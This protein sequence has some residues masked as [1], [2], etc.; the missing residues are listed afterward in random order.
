M[1]DH[2]RDRGDIEAICARLRALLQETRDL[3]RR[4]FLRALGRAGLAGVLTPGVAG[5]GSRARAAERPVT[6]LTYGGAWKTAIMEA[7]GDPFTRKTGIPMQYQE[8]Y[9]W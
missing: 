8:P 1:H 4:D 2:Q 5:F 3:D 6:M 9:S 7:Y